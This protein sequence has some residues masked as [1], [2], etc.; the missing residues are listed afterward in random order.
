MLCGCR[1]HPKGDGNAAQ[2]LTCVLLSHRLIRSWNWSELMDTTS[3]TANSLVVSSTR[4]LLND[5][6]CLTMSVV[7]RWTVRAGRTVDGVIFVVGFVCFIPRST[8]LFITELFCLLSNNEF[9]RLRWAAANVAE[10]DRSGS[11]TCISVC[12]QS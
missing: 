12:V 3:F 1:A 11:S 4:I 2:I 5:T 6:L 7:R 9:M 8:L 10:F